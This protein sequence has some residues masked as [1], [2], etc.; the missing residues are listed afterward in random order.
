AA[1]ADELHDALVWLGFLSAPEVEAGP[2]WSSLLGELAK[3]KRAARLD[4]P[5]ASV[6]IAAE[7]WPQLRALFPL[8]KLEPAVE[9]PV[10]S[11][12]V[13]WSADAAL[14]EIVRGR[15]EGL[16]PVT[17]TALA[18]PLGLAADAITPALLKLEA[19]GF[20]LRG[21]FT[22][23]ADGEEWCERRLLARI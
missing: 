15:L 17:A 21:R 14:V 4:L 7:R 22:P 9:A 3:Q 16:G 2:G 6:W 20:A 11:E 5:R 1:S 18:A 19:E 12:R 23:G 8:A 13:D 10:E